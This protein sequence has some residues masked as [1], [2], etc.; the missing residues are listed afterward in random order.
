MRVL[1]ELNGVTALADKPGD[2][3]SDLR[4]MEQARMLGENIIKYSRR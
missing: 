2:I 1:G 3:R 4:K